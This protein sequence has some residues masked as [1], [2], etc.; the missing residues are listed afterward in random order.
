MKDPLVILERPQLTAPYILIGLNGWL[1][2][3]EVST[4]SLDYIRRKVGAR[5]FAYVSTT[6]FYIYQIP[7]SN[8]ELTMR[9]K[10]QISE[11]LVKKLEIP[12][13][14]LFFWKS[15]SEHDL[16]LFLGYEPNLNW[17]EYAQV[18]LDL[19]RQYQSPRIYCLGGFFDQIPHTRDSRIHVTMSH[20]HMRSEFKNFANFGDYEGPCSFTTML[21]DMGREQGIEIAGISARAPIYI[22]DLNSKACYDLL[23]NVV[24]LI[25]LGIDLSD[26]RDAGEE[27]MEMMDKAFSENPTA[28]EQLKKMEELYDG[29]FGAEPYSDSDKGYDKL[30]EEM[31]KMKREG[32][33]PH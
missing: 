22:H 28:L 4:G 7:S 14:E 30:M 6:G 8:P 9:P 29:A 5:K 32:R 17:P 3:G 10:T 15:D 11:G 16:M 13:N 12:K 20:P 21:I 2:A 33:K 1:N 23:K 31:R 24:K 19:A 26:L 25:G 27:L 18:I